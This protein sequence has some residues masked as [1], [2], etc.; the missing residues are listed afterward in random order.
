[1]KQASLNAKLSGFLQDK[2]ISKIYLSFQQLLNKNIGTKKFVVCVSGGP[3]SLALAFCSKL[4]SEHTKNKVFYLVVDHNIRTNSAKE[5]KSVQK[6]LLKIHVK[7]NILT[8]KKSISKSIQKNARDHRY[9]LISAFCK[10]KKISFMLTAHHLDDQIENFYI[11]L[12]RGSG[13]YG[14]SSMKM[15]SQNKQRIH[16]LRP[17]LNITKKDLVHIAKKIFKTFVKDPSNTNDKFLRS[18]IRKLKSSLASEGLD[19]SRILKTISNL[20][21]AKEAIDFYVKKFQKK[22][23]HV[24][25]KNKVNIDLKLFSEQPA[26]IIYRVM[27][28][29]IQKRS[30]KD[31]PP[32]AKGLE[33]LISSI[34]SN[35]FSKTTLGGFTFSL[36]KHKI[37]MSKENRNA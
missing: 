11:R 28:E 6:N 4:Y 26:E 10:A 13:L 37:I 23:V 33:Y 2:V 18:R 36:D 1:M 5:A 3:D 22:H 17:F 35:N 31:Y 27:A 29:L 32:R 15:L 24:V 7:S 16:L 14:L 12:T 9:D 30:G 8:I 25:H 21:T 20:N 34:Q 19:Q